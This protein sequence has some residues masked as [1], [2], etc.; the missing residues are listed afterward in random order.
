MSDNNSNNMSDTFNFTAGTP[1]DNATM[2]NVMKMR[3]IEL[4]QIKL[5]L[6]ERE[7]ELIQQQQALNAGSSTHLPTTPLASFVGPGDG[8]Y[9]DLNDADLDG[10]LAYKKMKAD[11]EAR[12]AAREAEYKKMIDDLKEKALQQIIQK[13]LDDNYKAE[14]KRL[15]EVAIEAERE[16]LREKT[17]QIQEECRMKR[18]MGNGFYMGGVPVVI[19]GSPIM[20]IAGF[21]I[22]SSAYYLGGIK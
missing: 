12:E 20:G 9:L 1:V 16:K 5:Q 17:R 3:L 15:E 8:I 4:K 7:R 21:G 10:Y 11:Q 13:Q 2:D 6:D 14:K 19:N 22:G 18:Q